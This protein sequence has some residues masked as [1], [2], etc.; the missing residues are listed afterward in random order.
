[1][2]ARMVRALLFA[3]SR[4]GTA[5]NGTFRPCRAHLLLQ[6]PETT[7]VSVV[8]RSVGVMRWICRSAA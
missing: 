7:S 3:V 1:M 2:R 5:S 6:G 4:V 8:I